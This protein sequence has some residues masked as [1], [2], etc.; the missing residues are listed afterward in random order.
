MVR[1]SPP[2]RIASKQIKYSMIQESLR[3]DSKEV[4]SLFLPDAM[5]LL[6][7]GCLAFTAQNEYNV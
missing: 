3:N 4:F 1:L 6:H 5:P 2:V 7:V